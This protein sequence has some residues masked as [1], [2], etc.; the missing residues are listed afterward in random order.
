MV[1]MMRVY[2]W[3]G[4]IA[5]RPRRVVKVPIVVHATVV[6]PPMP[7]RYWPWETRLSLTHSV[8]DVLVVVVAAV[9]VVVVVAHVVVVALVVIAADPVR[10]TPAVVSHRYAVQSSPLGWHEWQKETS[11]ELS[12][13]EEEQE[14]RTNEYSVALRDG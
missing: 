14:Y 1:M 3:S 12:C 10:V 13:G 2:Y 5:T 9:V 4:R 7:V 11:I 8:L 6:V